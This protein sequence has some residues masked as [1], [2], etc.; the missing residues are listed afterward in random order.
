MID[1]I[2]CSERLPKAGTAPYRSQPVLLQVSG[3]NG[4][5]EYTL[6]VWYAIRCTDGRGTIRWYGIENNGASPNLPTNYELI[7]DDQAI[8]W[9]EWP[10][11]SERQT[12]E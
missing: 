9:A 8:A 11:V 1:W 3:M 7:A 6:D 10:S 12:S 4:D 5:F 2:P